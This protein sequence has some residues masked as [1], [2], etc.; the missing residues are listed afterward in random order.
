[1]TVFFCT[2]VLVH[3]EF[4]SYQKKVYQDLSFSMDYCIS[5]L[6]A[7]SRSLF[8]DLHLHLNILAFRIL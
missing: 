8:V 3:K 2:M 7:D 4:N 6:T 1:M 5:N